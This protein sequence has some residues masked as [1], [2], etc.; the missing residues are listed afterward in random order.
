MLMKPKVILA[1]CERSVVSTGYFPKKKKKPPQ[2]V[3]FYGVH[4]LNCESK[5]SAFNEHGSGLS[6]FISWLFTEHLQI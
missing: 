3:S 5:T 6:L 1:C 2:T 4:C